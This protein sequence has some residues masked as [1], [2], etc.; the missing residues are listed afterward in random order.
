MKG[1]TR[2]FEISGSRAVRLHVYNK[3][4]IP[5]LRVLPLRVLKKIKIKTRDA[6]LG[7]SKLFGKGALDSV[8]W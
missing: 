1:T 6:D 2:T 4:A 7:Y 8:A 3:Q 5:F